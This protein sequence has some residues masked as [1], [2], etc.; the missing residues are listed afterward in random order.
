MHI[1]IDESGGFMTSPT[2]QSKVSCVAAL[3]VPSCQ[4]DQLLGDFRELKS[5]WGT[6]DEEAKGSSLSEAQVAAVISLLTRYDIILDICGIDVGSHE[7]RDVTGFKNGWANKMTESLTP[8]HLP[9]VVEDIH[10]KKD[11]LMAMSNQLFV[12]SL[13]VISLV[14][15][16]VRMAT[17]YYSLR[18]PKELSSFSWIVDAKDIIV[19]EPEKW[20]SIMMLPVMETQSIQEPMLMVEEG[21]YS[22]FDRFR[23]VLNEIPLRQK[24]F[25][26]K[27]PG[28]FEVTDIKMV[29]QEKFAFADSKTSDGLQLVDI[30]ASAFTRAMNG[31]LQ[32]SG[33]GDLGSL[34]VRR[35]PYGIKW[36]MLS[37][38]PPAE[39]GVSIT[40][41]NFHGY[42]ME[43][44]DKKTK[45]I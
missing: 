13:S 10:K 3:V 17:L 16:I 5:S 11:F 8:E 24:G 33:W 37:A 22:F 31:N 27:P 39:S 43:Q 38:N 21:D 9:F 1:Y 36:I 30:L 34:I 20:W 41:R 28:P 26:H 23:K 18:I 45:A 19:T 42:V 35:K 6:S 2:L 7:E 14:D 40:K 44:I 29:M 32:Q 15:R 25:R 12:Q 4:N